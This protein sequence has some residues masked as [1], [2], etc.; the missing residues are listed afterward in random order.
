MNKQLLYA[1]SQVG[2]GWWPL[3]DKY[4]PAIQALDPDCEFE[5]K[6][7]FGTLRLQAFCGSHGYAISKLEQQAEEESAKICEYCGKPGRLRR[8]NRVWMLTLCDECDLLD[9]ESTRLLYLD[10]LVQLGKKC[11]KIVGTE[12]TMELR[13]QWDVFPVKNVL[14]SNEYK[15]WYYNLAYEEREIAAGWCAENEKSRRVNNV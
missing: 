6:E 11:E 12:R 5:P 9:K 3:L 15:E 2:M 13:E 7:K 8:E 1:Y 10:R 14:Q 4:I